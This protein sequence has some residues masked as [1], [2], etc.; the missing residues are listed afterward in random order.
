MHLLCFLGQ[1]CPWIRALIVLLCEVKAQ[2]E[3][4][5]DKEPDYEHSL[6]HAQLVV[7]D[8]SFHGD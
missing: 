7:G 8:E 5:D 6:H 1:S 4:A 2:K 3:A